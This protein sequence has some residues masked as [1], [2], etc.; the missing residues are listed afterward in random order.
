[1]P[2]GKAWELSDE[3]QLTKLVRAFAHEYART[4]SAA[5]ALLDEAFPDTA[6]VLLPE[7]ER[8][9]GIATPAA[10]IAERRAEVIVRLTGR[11]GQSPGYYEDIAD[12]LGIELII[13]E[14]RELVAGFSVGEYVT[15]G[16]WPYTF[17]VYTASGDPVPEILRQRFIS[18]KPGHMLVV[19]DDRWEMDQ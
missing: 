9:V 7:W 14:H 3:K 15:N 2:P 13:Q 17:R 10:T 6:T 18:G 5:L 12:Q 8:L 19:F 1:M 4:E 11:G 16:D